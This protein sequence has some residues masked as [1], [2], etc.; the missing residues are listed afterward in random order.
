MPEPEAVAGDPTL[1]RFAKDLERVSK[2]CGDCQR[3]YEGWTFGGAKKAKD[4]RVWGTCE[5]CVRRWEVRQQRS[6]LDDHIAKLE[7]RMERETQRELLIACVR[8]LI[9]AYRELLTLTIGTT[10]HTSTEKR[11][12]KLEMHAATL[13]TRR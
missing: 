11:L 4:G 1:A 10:E 6:K 12:E 7:G 5:Q 13:Q 8:A 3:K 2:R 9:E